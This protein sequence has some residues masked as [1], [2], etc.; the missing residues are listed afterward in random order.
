MCHFVAMPSLNMLT[1]IAAVIIAIVVVIIFVA[2]DD[3]GE[4]AK[5]T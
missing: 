4:Q 1:F 2:V 5:N 3:E